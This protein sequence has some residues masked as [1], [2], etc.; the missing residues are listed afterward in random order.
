MIPLYVRGILS[1][2]EGK[3][4]Q[5]ALSECPD[6]KEEIERWKKINNAYQTIE[7]T[8]PQ[9]SD[10]VYSRI[11]ERI[12][13]KSRFSLLQRVIPSQR[14]S[15]ALVAAQLLII[16]A[17]GVYVMNL[18]NEYRT[19]TAPSMTEGRLLRINIVFKENATEAEIRNLLLQMNARIV[20]GPCS[21]GLYI[22]GINS[23]E[24]FDDALNTLSKNKIVVMAERAY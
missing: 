12:T 17:L 16:I 6:L 14:V 19:L 1:D 24:K 4:F 13:E 9:P 11:T 7:R 5:M 8:L 3:E 2:S 15:L 23:Q 20:E 10:R 18:K 22:I 21:S